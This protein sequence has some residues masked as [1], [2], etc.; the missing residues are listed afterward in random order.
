MNLPSRDQITKALAS[1]VGDPDTGVVRD[2]LPDLT[3]A[4]VAL[5]GACVDEDAIGERVTRVVQAPE[6][7]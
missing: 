4:I 6:T 2:V 1:A 7:R 3:D 5:L